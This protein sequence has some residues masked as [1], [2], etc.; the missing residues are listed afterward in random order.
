MAGILAYKQ[1]EAKSES[2]RS[3][4][5]KETHKPKANPKAGVFE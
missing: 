2:K 1:A 4:E 5:I 3:K